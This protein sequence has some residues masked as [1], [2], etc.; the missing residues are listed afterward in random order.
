[1]KFQCLGY[2]NR[3]KMD[4]LTK[5]ELDA[6][7]SE[8]QIHL[9]KFLEDGNVLIDAG[10]AKEMKTLQRTGGTII[11]EDTR[12]NNNEPM[13]GSSFI[14]EAQDMEEA[15]EIASKHPTV[16]VESGEKLGWKIEIRPIESFKARDQRP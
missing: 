4:E 9:D 5:E 16:Q 15:I 10:I 7:M 2:F 3:E 13:I 14:I 1:M 12:P 11:I 6:I 8:C